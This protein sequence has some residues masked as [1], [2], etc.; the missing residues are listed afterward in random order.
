MFIYRAA[1][2]T[3]PVETP[4][5]SLREALQQA[6]CGPALRRAGRFNQLAL[7]GARQC[8]GE[9]SLP[10]STDVFI[11]SHNG[12]MTDTATVLYDILVQHQLPMPFNFINTQ[13]NSACYYVAS[14]LGLRGSSMVCS[15]HE[16]ALE[17]ALL[18]AMSS[19]ADC[20]LV[21]L[22]EEWSAGPFLYPEDQTG[23]KHPANREGSCWFLLSP[24]AL[25]TPPLARI[26]ALSLSQ[27]WPQAQE[28]LSQL[29]CRD[30]RVCW[31]VDANA[32]DRLI[33]AGFSAVTDTRD[34]LSALAHTESLVHWLN[35]HTG[36]WYCRLRSHADGRVMLL[37]IA[38]SSLITPD[39]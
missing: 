2:Y 22:T 1:H 30:E 16:M 37:L 6:G 4:R 3:Q 31:D 17:S 20:S 39:R 7:L 34:T 10:A 14:E 28:V 13:N 33:A 23:A 29:D 36:Q 27:T 26:H 25:D 11:A 18:L 12:N 21:G 35:H 15:H 38:N 19:L 32:A 9:L 5:T 8:C 24:Q